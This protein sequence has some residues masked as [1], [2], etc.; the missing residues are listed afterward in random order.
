MH[1]AIE[2]YSDRTLLLEKLW[3]STISL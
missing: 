1:V 2:R 3:E